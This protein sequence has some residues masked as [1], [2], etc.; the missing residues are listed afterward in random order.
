MAAAGEL[1][2]AALSGTPGGSRRRRMIGMN[3]AICIRGLRGQEWLSLRVGLIPII[4][5]FFPVILSEWSSMPALN[6]LCVL[7]FVSV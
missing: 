5:R 4:F 1:I 6:C 3:Q 7:I 2:D